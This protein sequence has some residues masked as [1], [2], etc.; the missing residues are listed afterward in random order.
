VLFIMRVYHFL[1]ETFSVFAILQMTF[2]CSAAG[3]TA[4][5]Y[6]VALVPF[7]M[8]AD[9]SIDYIENGVRDMIASRMS[10]D[11]PIT[12]IEQ[13]LVQDELSNISARELT[14][15][16]LMELGSALQADY[17]IGGSISKMG[18]T[19]SIDVTILNISKGGTTSSVFTQSLGLDELIPHMMVL[20]QEI[21]DTIAREGETA[22]QE[23]TGA[24]PPAGAETG[25]AEKVQGGE[26]VDEKPQVPAA[27]EHDGEV[28]TNEPPSDEADAEM[29]T[30]PES[31]ETNESPSGELRERLLQRESEIDSLDENPA[32]QKSIDNLESDADTTDEKASNE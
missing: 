9:E 27:S 2:L 16:K 10:Y 11:A 12:L 22:L 17:V 6:T 15:E 24:Q 19:V 32:Y 8:N 4:R 31:V 5:D 26:N 20:T 1:K 21:A 13:G 23:S 30:Q 3:V 25:P 18:N 14:S 29:D 7:R 28:E